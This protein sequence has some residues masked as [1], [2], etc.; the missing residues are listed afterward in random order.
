MPANDLFEYAIIRIVPRVEREEFLNAGILLFCPAQE[1]L[2]IAYELNEEKLRA[3]SEAVDIGAIKEQLRAFEQ[4]CAGGEQAGAIGKL[5]P[6]ERF[7][8]LTAPRSTIV[9]T[10]PVHTGLC[11]NAEETLTHL[12]VTLVR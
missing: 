9:Q 4:V 2:R 3:F 10:S 8:W 1:F 6:G 5:P 11:G 12:L 7:R